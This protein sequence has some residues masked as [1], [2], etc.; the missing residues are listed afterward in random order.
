MYKAW[1]GRWPEWV[2]SN[3]TLRGVGSMGASGAV[4]QGERNRK[5]QGSAGQLPAWNV[6]HGM[7]PQVLRNS[8]FPG[9]QIAFGVEFQSSAGGRQQGVGVSPRTQL[10]HAEWG[11]RCDAGSGAL[12]RDCPVQESQGA[13]GQGARGQGR[14]RAGR[15]G[16]AH[17][18][19]KWSLPQKVEKFVTM[20]GVRLHFEDLRSDHQWQRGVGGTQKQEYGWIL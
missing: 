6:V 15:E 2:A 19:R 1:S 10:M 8:V 14:K 20:H 3:P 13:R 5:Q 11:V 17:A 4:C 9:V 7:C 12:C 18:R 16:G